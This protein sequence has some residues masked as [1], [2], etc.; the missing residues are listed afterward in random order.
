MN[1]Q[2]HKCHQHIQHFSHYTNELYTSKKGLFL[3]TPSFTSILTFFADGSSE[4][5]DLC[6]DIDPSTGSIQ[7]QALPSPIHSRL[8][9]PRHQRSRLFL[10]G[11]APSARASS[12]VASRHQLAPLPWWRP[13][14]SSRLLLGGVAPSSLVASRRALPLAPLPCRT[15][16]RR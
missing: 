11:V 10:G 6:T 9:L 4:Q 7:P 1:L 14:I 15:Q 8:F 3:F 2:P 16:T 12:L 5:I 13:A